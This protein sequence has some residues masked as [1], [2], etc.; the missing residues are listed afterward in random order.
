MPASSKFPW[1]KPILAGATL[2]DRL[3]ASLGTLLGIG[4]TGLFCALSFGP[5]PFLPLI[6]APIGASAVLLFAV[7]ASPLA[8]PWPII[9]GNTI[10]AL[11]GVTV[12]HYLPHPLLATGVAVALAIV[13]MSLTR[14]LHPPGGAAALTAVIGGS[15]VADAG[16][17]FPFVPIAINSA[18][19]V[20]LGIGFHKLTRRGYPHVAQ[21]PAVNEHKTKDRPAPLRVGV[22]SADIDAALIKMGESYDIDRG[23]LDRLLRE[24]EAQILSRS[25]GDMLSAEIMSRDVVTVDEHTTSAVARGLLLDH[26]LRTLPVL[27]GDRRLVG[28][29]GLRELAKETEHISG[30]MSKAVT[31][32]P[33]TPIVN[34]IPLL[35]N[36]R[37]H[38]VVIVD[39][40]SRIAGIVTQTDLLVALARALL[41][42]DGRKDVPKRALT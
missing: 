4:L 33:G 11:V 10:S 1:F 22:Q 7:P 30:S 35:S 41:T 8:Q 34:L 25:H 5:D 24:V 19:L 9:G 13:A 36:G 20:L 23:D 42:R 26:D 16:Y 12:V 21:P 15:A 31:A 28:T 6:V 18:L 14:S 29:V 39:G 17:L 32:T 3:I 37:N 27:D 40:D 2:R 38:A